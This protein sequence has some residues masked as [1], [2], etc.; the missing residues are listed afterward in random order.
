MADPNYR[1]PGGYH[2]IREIGRLH[3]DPNL[4]G[5]VHRLGPVQTAMAAIQNAVTARTPEARNQQLERAAEQAKGL[6][7]GIAA[8]ED[9]LR[10]VSENIEEL[11]DPTGG[12][13][14]MGALPRPE[15]PLYTSSRP[16]YPGINSTPIDADE[17]GSTGTARPPG[18]VESARRGTPA[19]D[20]RE[21]VRL[22]G[23]DEGMSGGPPRPDTGVN[24]S[25][26]QVNIP[27]RYEAPVMG[28]ETWKQDRNP[29]LGEPNETDEGVGLQLAQAG[30]EQGSGLTQAAVTADRGETP[31]PG[32]AAEPPRAEQEA[33]RQAQAKAPRKGGR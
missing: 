27:T 18:W 28:A 23:A 17:L 6:Q 4:P 22:M 32:D 5:L 12:R 2:F 3:G 19:D 26:N 1:F 33:I 24:Q 10:H 7:A 30:P 14:L 13:G 9:A 15:R 29:P 20:N 21:H 25:M 31:Q 11:N 16:A 8:I